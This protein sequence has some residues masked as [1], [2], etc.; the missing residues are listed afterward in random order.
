MDASAVPVNINEPKLINHLLESVRVNV[1]IS[2][3]NGF[4]INAP[5]VNLMISTIPVSLESEW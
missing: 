4:T 2:D 3:A 1:T 5:L